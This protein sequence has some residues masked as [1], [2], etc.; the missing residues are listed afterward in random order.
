MTDIDIRHID[1]PSAW[2]G[3]DFK[4]PDDF[5]VDLDQRHLDAFAGVVA[6]AKKDGVGLQELTGEHVAMPEIEADLLAI[7]RELMD[8]RSLV[9]L[10][11]FPLQDMS[12]A[13]LGIV[14]WAI[15]TYFGRGVSQSPMG[16]RLGY[17]TDVSEP[18]KRDRGYRS[19]RELNLHTDSDDIVGLLCIRQAKS[20]GMSRLASAPAIHNEIAASRPDLLV[21]LYEGFHYHWFGEQPP[22]QGAVTDFK[23]PVFGMADGLLSICFLREF[24]N[25]GAEELGEPL[26]D[27]Q[28]EALELFEEIANRDDI[29]LTYRLEPGCASF[30][31]NYTV[32]HSRTAFED[33]PE[34]ARRR[35]MFRLW[36]KAEPSRPV[37]PNLRRYYGDDGMFID[38]RTN[39]FFELDRATA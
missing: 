22:G 12:E 17:V 26:T 16:D 39:T 11:G 38:G 24:I 20:G 18:G 23:I 3:S 5:A 33:W 25:M 6:R 9:I 8:G 15:G 14:Y 4:S 31:N 35:L 7:R 19:A 2:K 1:H 30:I 21:P 36:L 32:L 29:V 27:T 10:R 37:H 13:E 28:V 34:K